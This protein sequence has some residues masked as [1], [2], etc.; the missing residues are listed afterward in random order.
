MIRIGGVEKRELWIRTL[1][2]A[3]FILELRRISRP[4]NEQSCSIN[5]GC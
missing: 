1:A 5:D 2:L 4:S 3:D